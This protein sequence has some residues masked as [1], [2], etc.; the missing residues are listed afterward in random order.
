MDERHLVRRLR[1]L[2][3]PIPPSMLPD[4]CHVITVAC[5]DRKVTRPFLLE[6][7]NLFEEMHEDALK[8][9][10]ASI[11]HRTVT[12]LDARQALRPGGNP[13]KLA[14]LIANNYEQAS[15]SFARKRLQLAS[16]VQLLAEC[17]DDNDAVS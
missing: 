16:M 8:I 7:M 9:E 12:L 6:M 5:H 10:R 15:T 2:D 14:N 1:D 11:I 17:K 13:G 4:Y 3:S